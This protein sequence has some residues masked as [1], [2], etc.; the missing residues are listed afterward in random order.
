[1]LS[2][3]DYDIA[4]IGAGDPLTGP[5]AADVLRESRDVSVVASVSPD[6]I[7]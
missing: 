2:D 4:L 5:S 7:R 6:F 3:A 1:M